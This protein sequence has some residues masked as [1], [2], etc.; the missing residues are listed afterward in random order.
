[1][2]ELLKELEEAKAKIAEI[3]KK[4]KEKQEEK[5]RRWKPQ[6]G[7]E[8][9]WVDSSGVISSDVWDNDGLDNCRWRIGN[10]YQTE[11]ECKFAR[12]KLKVIA[13]L[14]EFEEPKD[15]E[16]NGEKYHY[17]ICYDY[18]KNIV[19]ISENW[20]TKRSD[21]YFESGEKAQQA[22]NAIGVERIKKYYLEVEE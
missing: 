9:W 13:E 22:I 16:W 12:E 3:E 5:S 8:Y 6:K 17:Y 20:T 14:K 21:I 10:C 15:R 19:K 11:E 7:D 18:P 2:E 4:I 1:M